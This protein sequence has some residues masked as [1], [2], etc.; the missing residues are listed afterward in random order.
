M[1]LKQ[2]L[3]QI[4]GIC[5]DI[6]S[7]LGCGLLESAYQAV[8]YHELTKAGYSVKKEV[9]I[10]IMYHDEII[11]NAY[12]A[13]LVVDDSIIIE[14][15]AV[16]ELL[17]EHKVQLGTYL[18]ISNYPVGLL[19]NFHEHET[20]IPNGIHTMSRSELINKYKLNR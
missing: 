14:L 5:M 4:K 15:K 16:K 17:T 19:V 20:L 13:D 2:K 6:H 3:Y 8:L 12:R 18:Q 10:P 7:E 11:E 9:L 1:D